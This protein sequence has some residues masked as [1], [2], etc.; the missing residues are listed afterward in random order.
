MK[1]YRSLD[2][3]AEAESQTQLNRLTVATK[4]VAPIAT[5]RMRSPEALR[6]ARPKA[7]PTQSHTI[8]TKRMTAMHKF[9][10]RA[11]LAVVPIIN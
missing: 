5:F 4:I 11:R 9:I 1:I 8:S 7:T 2:Y 3:A 10:F 6:L